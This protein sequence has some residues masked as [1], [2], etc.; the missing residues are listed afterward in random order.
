MRG[1]RFAFTLVEIMLA[2]TILALV[3][4]AIYSS[5]TAILRASKV[6]TEATAAVQ[7]SRISLRVL[8]DSLSSVQS[9]AQKLTLCEKI[10]TYIHLVRLWARKT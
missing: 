10:C 9:F 8:E 4:T 5:W 2:I 6:A 7:R 3:L 1:N